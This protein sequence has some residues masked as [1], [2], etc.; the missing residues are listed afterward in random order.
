MTMPQPK[1]RPKCPSCHG[2]GKERHPL[3]GD[4]LPCFYCD[5]QG[6]DPYY[7]KPEE[8]KDDDRE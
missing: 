7:T 2:E 4:M 5:G 1:S 8:E 6:Y 3:F